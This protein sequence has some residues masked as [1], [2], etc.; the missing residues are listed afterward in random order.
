MAPH[1]GYRTVCV[2]LSP[3]P[4]P[5]FNAHIFLRTLSRFCQLPLLS[6]PVVYAL[7][8]R[9]RCNLMCVR[10]GMILVPE[11]VAVNIDA[12]VTPIGIGL[13]GM[14]RI[15]DI[16]HAEIIPLEI[17]A[18]ERPEDVELIHRRRCTTKA[19]PGAVV[20][21]CPQRRRMRRLELT[22]PLREQR[23]VT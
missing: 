5:F 4:S 23:I 13:V 6:L 21:I 17:Q 1:A 15:A 9:H 14:A 20:R 8:G 18:L 19:M 10:R 11:F 3:L 12:I 16:T 2:N 22:E 7:Y